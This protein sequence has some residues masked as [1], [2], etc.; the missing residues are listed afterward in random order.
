MTESAPFIVMVW[1]HDKKWNSDRF[2]EG[3]LSP[4]KIIQ[5][6]KNGVKK[7]WARLSLP[8]RHAWVQETI[9]IKIRWYSNMSERGL[10]FT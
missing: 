7:G 2:F 1:S 5:N 10:E 6:F 9:P 8:P 3:E 4:P